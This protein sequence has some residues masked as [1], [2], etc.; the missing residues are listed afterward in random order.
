MEKR[1]VTHT[2][3]VIEQSFSA[4]PERVFAAFADHERKRLWLAEQDCFGVE[5]V[6]MDFRD[7]ASE[8]LDFE[9]SPLANGNNHRKLEPSRRAMFAYTMNVNGRRVSASLVTVELVATERGTDLTFTEHAAFFD[10]GD[11]SRVREFGWREVLEKL[12]HEIVRSERL[13]QRGQDEC[14]N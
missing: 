7:V 12:G 2:T 1:C 14:L 4:P 3:F 6:D 11:G 10:G 5:V 8:H 9:G 13:R